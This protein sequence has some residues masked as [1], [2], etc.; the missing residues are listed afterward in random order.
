MPRDRPDRAAAAISAR[1]RARPVSCSTSM[2]AARAAATP[3]STATSFPGLGRSRSSP[4]CVLVDALPTL[5]DI[6]TLGGQRGVAT[7]ALFYHQPTP[8]ALRETGRLD[9]LD[10]VGRESPGLIGF[11]FNNRLLLGGFA[12][13]PQSTPGSLNPFSDPAQENLT[14]LLLDAHRMLNFQSAELQKIPAF[15]ELF[16][17]AFPTE[18][19]NFAKSGSLNDLVSDDT[20]LRATAT[21]LRTAVTRNTKFDRFLAGD[22]SALTDSQQNG[23]RLFFTKATA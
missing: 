13:E 2:S 16:R 23:A 22:D 17:Q 4:G 12:G 18:A 1:R 20:E 7:P 11:A 19:A 3:T 15:V 9:E 8:E 10:S 14:L 6:F 21:F 5:T